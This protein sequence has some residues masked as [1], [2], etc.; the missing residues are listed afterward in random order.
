MIIVKNLS[1]SY[2]E[3]PVLQE[4]SLELPASGFSV[5]VGPN[6]A[7]KSTLLYLLMA[8]LQ[9][10][11]GKI[12][13]YNKDIKQ[14]R[15]QELAAE[16]AFIPQESHSEFDY[17]VKD[18]VLMGRYPYLGLWQ[19]YGKE[20]EESVAKALEMMQLNDL[21]ERYL[22]ELS[23][24]EKQRV[25]LARALAQ[26]T[27]YILLDESLSQLDIN[28]QVEIIRL[29]KELSTAQGKAIVLVSHNLNLAANYADKMI[30]LKQG[31]LIASG[32]PNEVMQEALLAKLFD[33]PLMVQRNPI[34]GVNNLIYP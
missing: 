8:Y 23:G 29:L 34:S 6:G 10:K 20:D 5:L 26:N 19:R 3:S 7:G 9:P 11:T 14:Y 30:L 4:I 27:K 18:T 1:Y 16:I 22:S 33:L 28:F 21:K 17:L 12:S 31:R 15:P 13:L 24:G 25:Y 32:T 2:S